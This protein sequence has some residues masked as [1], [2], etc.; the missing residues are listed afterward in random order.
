MQPGQNEQSDDPVFAESPPPRREPMF[1]LPVVVIALIGLC[2]AI[3]AAR[4]F[5]LAPDQ[6]I[7]LLVRFAFIPERYSGDY[8][9]DV[10]ALVSPVTYSLLHGDILHLGVNVIWLAAFGSPLANRIGTARFLVFWVGTSLAAVALH[11]GLHSLDGVPVVGASGAISGMMGAAARFGFRIERFEG[12]AAFSG[13]VLPIGQV[14]RHRMAVTFLVVWFLV[15]VA[16]G[17]GF[18]GPSGAGIAWEA[19]IGG[20]AA[21][22]FCI[23]LFDRR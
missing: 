2:A 7:G 20:F 1:N 21:G 14:L 13:P 9:I 6:D 18:S 17:L 22:F 15:N 16:M 8:L 3:H 11:Y 5:V 12:R 10:Y 4:V 19:H 23:R